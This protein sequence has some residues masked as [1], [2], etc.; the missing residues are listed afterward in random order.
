ME[1]TRYCARH[2]N[3][4]SSIRC[5]KCETPICVDCLVH[6]PVGMRCP[7]CAQVNRVPTYDVPTIYLARGLAA[8]VVVALAQSVALVFIAPYALPLL[9]IGGVVAR[10]TPFLLLALIAAMGLSVGEAVS[11]S[12]NRKR[13]TRLKLV[14]GASMLVAS[15]V[16]FYMLPAGYLQAFLMHVIVGI[17]L[18]TWLA[19]RRF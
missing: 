19:I 9:A 1:Q 10:L 6:G 2:P 7:D 12:T 3:T 13:G 15:T 8:G 11:L 18:A 17:A 5:G 14:A 4:E 16:I